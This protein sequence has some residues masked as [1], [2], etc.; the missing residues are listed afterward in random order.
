MFACCSGFWSAAPRI[1]LHTK[2]LGHVSEPLLGG[3]PVLG[4]GG[5]ADR[6]VLLGRLGL[7]LLVVLQKLDPLGMLLADLFLGAWDRCGSVRCPC[8]PR[9]CRCRCWPGSR[10]G[11]R[12]LGR[13][14][15][16]AEVA[17][18]ETVQ[19]LHADIGHVVLALGDGGG[20]DPVLNA[21]E[22]T[23]SPSMPTMM[24]SPAF[25]RP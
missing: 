7:T 22:D 4:A 13:V 16:L 11:R 10:A 8:R 23:E 15:R 5:D 14:A 24:I 1:A 2:F 17:V 25:R 6:H 18:H 19:V 21:V 3:V 20:D 12:L 9:P